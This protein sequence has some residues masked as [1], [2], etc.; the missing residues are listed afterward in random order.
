MPH[1]IIADPPSLEEFYRSYEPWQVKRDD[2]IVLHA[3]GAYLRHDSLSLLVEGVVVEL[4]PPIH[5]FVVVE[6][7]KKQLSVRCFPHPS[8]ARTKGV[9]ALVWGV[10]QQ[11]L[12]LG[13]SID[14]TNIEL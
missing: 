5:L 4:A 14:R 9:K 2:G 6:E 3:R 13:G 11:I 12:K 10:G 7:K 8:P 1:V